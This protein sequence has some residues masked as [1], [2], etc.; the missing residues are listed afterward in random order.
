MRKDEIAFQNKIMN[1]L[2]KSNIA[3]R[4]VRCI[5]I[6]ECLNSYNENL[7]HGMKADEAEERAIERIIGY[8][9]I[10][11][12]IRKESISYFSISVVF[13]MLILELLICVIGIYNADIIG[14]VEIINPFGLMISIAAIVSLIISHRRRKIL[15]YVFIL[16]VFVTSLSNNV[17][18]LI[19]LYRPRTGDYYFT[20]FYSFPGNFLVNT[21]SLIS[22]EPLK[23]EMTYT[24]G[25]FD[26]Q[27]IVYSFLFLTLLIILIRKKVKKC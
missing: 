26:F 4:K 23:Y 3:D 11:S 27:L 16:I 15:D 24:K 19:N 18:S 7:N 2:D 8:I 1:I 20:L 14:V 6:S 22:Q 17:L 9:D 21:Y 10:D 12:K 5:L 25:Y 13:I